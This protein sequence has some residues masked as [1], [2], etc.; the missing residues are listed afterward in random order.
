VC[1][2]RGGFT[3][4]GYN[5]N[6]CVVAGVDDSNCLNKKL[7]DE[8][9]ASCK[10]GYNSVAESVTKTLTCSKFLQF[11]STE[12][13]FMWKDRPASDATNYDLAMSRG[14][15]LLEDRIVP[16]C[17]PIKCTGFSDTGLTDST[18][19][20]PATVPTAPGRSAFFDRE[21][22]VNNTRTI[23]LNCYSPTAPPRNTFP[24]NIACMLGYAT[25]DASAAPMPFKFDC[26]L[27]S[28]SKRKVMIG[29][30]FKSRS[31]RV[32]NTVPS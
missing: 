8:C 1:E 14:V 32:V 5:N 15:D 20:L 13:D 26:E 19:S 7:G 21:I 9:T 22:I 3:V 24:C 25:P 11:T 16:W 6:E 17:A 10:P 23:P 2:Q 31:C 30:I 12:G 28:G 29:D 4:D 27:K 18:L